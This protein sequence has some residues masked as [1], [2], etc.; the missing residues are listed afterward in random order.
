M[1]HDKMHE[2][3]QYDRDKHGSLL[4][5]YIGRNNDILSILPKYAEP[6]SVDLSNL[7]LD[8]TGYLN[9]PFTDILKGIN[10]NTRIY[11]GRVDSQLEK[12]FLQQCKEHEAS[13]NTL[14]TT[15]DYICRLYITFK[16]PDTKKTIGF[17]DV[18]EAFLF[19]NHIKVFGVD[20]LS[21][22][23][24]EFG[25]TFTVQINAKD[26]DHACSDIVSMVFMPTDIQIGERILSGV[27]EDNNAYPPSCIYMMENTK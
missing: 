6:I 27:Y 20:S 15:G 7:N 5:V 21:S 1:E 24:E 12:I 25:T 8:F 14:R 10:K 13:L 9:I 4:A 22:V 16:A 18:K 19:P 23:G 11:D 17:R 2:P 26:I 3:L